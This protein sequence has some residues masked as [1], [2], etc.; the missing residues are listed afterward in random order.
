MLQTP[1]VAAGKVVRCPRC[2]ATMPAPAETEGDAVEAE[3]DDPPQGR[4][5]AGDRLAPAPAPPPPPSVQADARLSAAAASLLRSPARRYGFNCQYCSSRLEA[6]TAVAGQ[7]GQCPTCNQTIVIPILDRSGRLID[8]M[9]GKVV[10]QAP[11]PVHAYAAAGDHAPKIERGAD[12]HPYI[13]CPRCS[14]TSPITANNC[15]NCGMP[16]TMEG[17]TLEAAGGSSGMAT[18]SLVLGIV[19]LPAFCTVVVPLLAVVF[20]VVAMRQIAR[21]GSGGNGMALAGVICGAVGLLMSLWLW[22]G[23]GL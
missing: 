8:P 14:A 4:H 16:F 7:E 22:L 17:T 10:R 5:H 19:G 13:R 11:H 6:N 23:T 21:D 18:A 12:G 2:K 20:G 15:R 3:F 1:P 9:T